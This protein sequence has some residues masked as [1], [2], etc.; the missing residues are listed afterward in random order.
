MESWIEM[1]RSGIGILRESH[2]WKKIHRDVMKNKNKYDTHDP[3]AYN[4]VDENQ[5]QIIKIH[6]YIYI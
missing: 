1:L 5:I 3:E 4:L 2:N 6:N